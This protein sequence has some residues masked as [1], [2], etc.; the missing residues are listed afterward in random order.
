MIGLLFVF[1][2]HSLY[3]KQTSYVIVIATDSFQTKPDKVF[4]I[5]LQFGLSGSPFY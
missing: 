3:F 2:F 5:I 1:Y 4:I